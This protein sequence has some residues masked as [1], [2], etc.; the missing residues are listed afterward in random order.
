MSVGEKIRIARKK[1][2]LTQ[3]ALAKKAGVAT[4]T[5]RQYE[6]GKRQPRLEQ[7]DLIADALEVLPRYFLE[8]KGDMNL[9]QNAADGY[10]ESKNFE[11]RI[12]CIK[13]ILISLC[14]G[15]YDEIEITGKWGNLSIPVY[16][17]GEQAITLSEE[18]FDIILESAE[19]YFK[20]WLSALGENVNEV[21]S[22]LKS[23][24]DSDRS[25][26]LSDMQ[27]LVLWEDTRKK[28]TPPKLEG[29]LFERG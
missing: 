12:D 19:T 15:Y 10:K 9:Y 28:K 27:R 21:T 16:G 25:K 3:E 2:G 22:D 11:K 6:L 24:L 4:I 7:L 13:S 29:S 26:N 18:S 5:I 17:K 23:F 1:A 20:Y 14:G 8:S